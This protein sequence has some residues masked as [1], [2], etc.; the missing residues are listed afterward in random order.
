[1]LRAFQD[2]FHFEHENQEDSD[3]GRFS[4]DLEDDYEDVPDQDEDEGVDR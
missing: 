4:D 3:D 1:M 2:R